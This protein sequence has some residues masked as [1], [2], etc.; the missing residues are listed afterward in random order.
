MPRPKQAERETVLSETRAL[1]L[2]AAAEEFSRAGFAG[3]NINR[4]STAA[5]FAKGT[6]YNHFASKRALMLALIDE[7]AAAHVEF[8]VAYVLEEQDPTRR[9]ERF[10]EAGFDFVSGHL[11]PSRVMLNNIYGPDAELKQRMYQGYQPLFQFIGQEI[12]ATGIDRGLFRPVD[13]VETATLLMTI[14]LGAG[15][16]VDEGGRPWLDPRHVATFALHALQVKDRKPG[17]ES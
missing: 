8:V 12:V 13:P 11:A 16:Q 6:I 15:S 5:G 7:T 17:E 10:F 1:L 2:Q 9:L 14:Y 3:A 4:I